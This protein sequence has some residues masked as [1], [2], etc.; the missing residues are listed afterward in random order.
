M[1]NNYSWY[2]L[3][4]Y[5]TNKDKEDHLEY[6]VDG[7]QR[8]TTLTLILIKLRHYAKKLNDIPLQNT[9]TEKIIHGA[10]DECKFWLV[11]ERYEECMKQLFE[12]EDNDIK[13]NELT[14]KDM[15]NNYSVI[16]SYINKKFDEDK[17]NN[18]FKRFVKFFI[19]KLILVNLS[20]VQTDAP[21]IF[22]VIN[23]RGV[24]L[25]PY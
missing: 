7:Q 16:S 19:E 12:K 20:I 4:T 18:K 11:H 24:R 13:T 25:R 22:E 21:M 3:N 10:E 5:V 2:Y 6:I 8:L 1:V 23:D 9:I 14:V 15:L 17:D